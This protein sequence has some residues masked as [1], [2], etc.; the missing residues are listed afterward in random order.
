MIDSK[1]EARQ[2]APLVRIEGNALRGAPSDDEIR[3]HAYKLYEL[4]GRMEGC[5]V[6]DWLTA[7]RHLTARKNR[8]NKV[9]FR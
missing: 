9:I 5:A 3:H 8:A 4:R 1:A 2:N 6:E 7:E